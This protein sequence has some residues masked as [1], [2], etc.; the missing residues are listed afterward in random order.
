MLSAYR[1][2]RQGSLKVLSGTQGNSAESSHTH[3]QL[4]CSSPF[5]WLPYSL[6]PFFPLLPSLTSLHHDDMQ[7]AGAMDAKGRRRFDVSAAAGAGDEALDGDGNRL[8]AWNARQPGQPTFQAGIDPA[9]RQEDDVPPRHLVD[10]QGP[11]RS[12]VQEQRARGRKSRVGAGQAH[13]DR[14]DTQQIA[15]PLIQILGPQ[16]GSLAWAGS[17]L[18][19][20]YPVPPA[21]PAHR[22]WEVGWPPRSSLA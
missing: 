14:L 11:A 7:P 17:E 6:F 5:P 18:R 21:P 9:G 15:A 1:P 16:A 10:Q 8:P 12:A 3:H 20:R 22:R 2:V 19:C 13:A 4:S